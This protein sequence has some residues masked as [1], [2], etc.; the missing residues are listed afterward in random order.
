[1]Q[2]KSKTAIL[3]LQIDALLNKLDLNDSRTTLAKD[4]SGG[5]KRKLSITIALIGDP[6]IIFLDEPTS[7]MV[8]DFK[9]D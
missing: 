5:Q 1:M 8:D 9:K 4:L 6:K 2:F 7:G 3:P